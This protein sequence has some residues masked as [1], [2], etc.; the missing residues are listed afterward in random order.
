[1][2]AQVIVDM[3][4]AINK[5]PDWNADLKINES[6]LTQSDKRETIFPVFCRHPPRYNEGC[7][8]PKIKS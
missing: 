2:D 3:T 7:M 4:L 6:D 5:N 1:M 8:F